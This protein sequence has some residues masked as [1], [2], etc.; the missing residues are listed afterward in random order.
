MITFAF[1]FLL[2][3]FSI[4]IKHNKEIYKEKDFNKKEKKVLFKNTNFH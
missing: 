4:I 2:S 1:K 3:F